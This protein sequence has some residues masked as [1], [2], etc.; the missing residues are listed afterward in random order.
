MA[1]ST[2][3]YL[4]DNQLEYVTLNVIKSRCFKHKSFLSQERGKIVWFQPRTF[5]VSFVPESTEKLRLG[6]L[7]LTLTTACSFVQRVSTLVLG[8]DNSSLLFG[9]LFCAL[10]RQYLSTRYRHSARHVQCASALIRYYCSTWFGQ[11]ITA[12]KLCDNRFN[13]HAAALV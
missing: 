8:T 7:P 9:D 1:I 10:V 5:S 13:T 4:S 2:K 11:L 3:Y 12:G 6:Q